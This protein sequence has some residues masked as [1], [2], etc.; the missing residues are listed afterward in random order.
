MTAA[1]LSNGTIGWQVGTSPSD[2]GSSH[3][4]GLVRIGAVI[5]GGL[6]IAALAGN[7]AFS[8][9]Q[10]STGTLVPGQAHVVQSSF[11]SSSRADYASSASA[12]VAPQRAVTT[13]R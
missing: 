11:G 1:Q 5:S 10:S 4:L 8:L 12:P 9:L 3:V 13:A 7:L 6:A 2:Q